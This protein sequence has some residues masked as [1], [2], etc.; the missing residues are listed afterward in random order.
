M[1]AALLAV[2]SLSAQAAV[3][4]LPRAYSHND[5]RQKRPLDDALDRG[6][7]AVE[8]DVHLRGKELFIGHMGGDIKPGVTL[9]KLYLDPLLKRVRANGGQVYRNGP[10]FILMVEFK[11]NGEESWPVLKEQL[12][13]Y[14]EMLTKFTP[15]A[16]EYGAVTV[17]I[18]GHTPDKLVR[19]EAHRIAGLDGG[20]GDRNSDEPTLYPVISDNW[21]A[22]FEWRGGRMSAEERSRLERAVSDAHGHARL[23]RFWGIPDR[24]ETWALLRDAGVDLI[25]TDH[26]ERLKTFLL[27]Q[28]PRAEPAPPQ[29]P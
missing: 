5:Y 18:T 23:L 27:A 10:T 25:N 13:P 4:P 29:A 26:L 6:F 7:C 1:L 2:L 11:S 16:T 15:T 3:V 14:A 21:A 17:V 22:R 8:A 24:E 9:R 20:F 12:A 28:A 19:A